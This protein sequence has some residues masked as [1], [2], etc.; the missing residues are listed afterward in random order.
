MA[1]AVGYIGFGIA[2]QVRWSGTPSGT[3]NENSTDNRI[4][5]LNAVSVGTN[6]VFS[7]GS[8]IP[9]I[10]SNV[11]I[12]DGDE[13]E[14]DIG[15]RVGGQTTVDLPIIVSA[16]GASETVDARITIRDSDTFT[17][18]LRNGLTWIT[19]GKTWGR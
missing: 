12:E 18:W 4:T 5:G 7:V 17:G 3:F 6:R 2:I 1:T 9:S 11:S 10:L 16:Y 8:P 13:I 19:D 15:N 14:F